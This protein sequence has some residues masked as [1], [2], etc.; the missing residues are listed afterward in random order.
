MLAAGSLL[1]AD[2]L[3]TR[4]CV[5]A[6]SLIVD[7]LRTY[8]QPV[9]VYLPPGAELRGGA[10]VV[11]DSAINSDM[12][13]MCAALAT[14]RTVTKYQL[15]MW[16]RHRLFTRVHAVCQGASGF[17]P[18]PQDVCAALST[19]VDACRCYCGR[20]ADTNVRGGVLEAEG[21]VEI[22]FR[23]PEL[24]AIMHRIDPVIAKLKASVLC[25]H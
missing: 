8:R 21:M 10:W 9:F 11:I 12:I 23:K 3:P 14:P 17:E 22:K 6:G 13:E 25:R 1:R 2:L 5:Q 4:S 7:E 20:Y 15:V 18:E 16:P 24:L 19:A